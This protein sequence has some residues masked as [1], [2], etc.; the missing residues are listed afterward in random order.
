M[1]LSCEMKT[2]YLQGRFCN[3][4]LSSV[5]RSISGFKSL[6]IDCVR[7]ESAF[8]VKIDYLD[9]VGEIQKRRITRMR[10]LIV[11]LCEK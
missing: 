3:L 10:K 11:V 1:L 5:N 9:E 4:L 2:L 8:R 7:C 6:V